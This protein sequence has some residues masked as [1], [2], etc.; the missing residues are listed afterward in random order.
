MFFF[1]LM[2]RRPPR[3]T[4]F[5]YTTLF[6]SYEWIYKNKFKIEKMLTEDFIKNL[7]RIMFGDVWKWAGE[8]RTTDKNIGV[9]HSQI[10][11]ELKKLIDDCKYWIENSTFEPDEIVVRFTHR[12]VKIHLFPNGNGRHSRLIGDIFINHG[13]GKKPFSW[14]NK[15][16]IGRAHV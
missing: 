11:I 14:G 8:F 4:L 12:I 9:D 16:K 15:D 2:I 1:F 6:R 5:P 13:F 7:H 3:S 10:R